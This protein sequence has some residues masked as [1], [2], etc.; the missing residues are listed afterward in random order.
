MLCTSNITAGKPPTTQSVKEP[1]RASM[2]PASE[3]SILF[4]VT[5]EGSSRY[6]HRSSLHAQRAAP[7]F[8]TTHLLL[9]HLYLAVLTM[10]QKLPMFQFNQLLKHMPLYIRAKGCCLQR[11]DRRPISHSVRLPGAL[12]QTP[13]IA[14][15]CLELSSTT[16]YS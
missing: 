14:K 16:L 7:C 13:R 10:I 6:A 3:L 15:C 8:E 12:A 2:H 9:S 5:L 1:S 4:R 11:S